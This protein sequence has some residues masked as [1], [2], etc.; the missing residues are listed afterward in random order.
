ME[1]KTKLK[2]KPKKKKNPL[3]SDR[4]PNMSKRSSAETLH[5]RCLPYHHV[6]H[7]CAGRGSSNKLRSK[8]CSKMHR[9]ANRSKS[10]QLKI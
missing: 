1:S 8:K 7:Y 10:L 3:D 4:P 5:K 9:R 2:I 6:T